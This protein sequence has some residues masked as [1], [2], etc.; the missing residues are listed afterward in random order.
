MTILRW[1]GGMRGVYR[2]GLEASRLSSVNSITG[3][4]D[5]YFR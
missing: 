4:S 3:I 2:T 5:D 1:G